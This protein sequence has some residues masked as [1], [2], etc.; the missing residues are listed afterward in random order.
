MPQKIPS[1]KNTD[2]YVAV[3]M[4]ITDFALLEKLQ[5]Y[6]AENGWSAVGAERS[7][8]VTYGTIVGE[9]VA[10]LHARTQKKR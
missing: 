7:T 3:R 4:H 9:A 8:R 2:R 1:K 5:A 10:Q 6:V